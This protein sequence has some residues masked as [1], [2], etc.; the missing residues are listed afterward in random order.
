MPE[1]E[2]HGLVNG[3]ARALLSSAV[4]FALDG[5]VRDRIIA[6]TRGNPLALLELPRGL[7]PTQLAGG[8][9]MPDARDLPRRIEESY[10]RRL[11]TLPD[12]ARRLLLVA[13]AEPVGDPLLLQRACERLG[14]ARSAAV[15]ATDGLL[16]LEERVTFRHPLAR[17]AVYRS[18]DA[19]G[20]PGG[21]PGAGGGD[22]SGR[23][24]RIGARGIW[25]R[26]PPGPTR[27]SRASWSCSAGRAQ[28]RGG[29][30]AAAAFLQRAVALTGDPRAAGRPSARGRPGQPRRGRVRRG[31]RA[32]GG[33]GG[34]AARRARAGPRGPAPGRG[35]VRPEP[36]R[37]RPAAAARRPRGSSRR[38]TCGS[39]RDTYLDAWSAALFA[40]RLAARRQPARRLPR[41]GDRARSG[42]SSAAARPAAGRPRADLHRGARR[43]D[44]RAP[45]RGRRVR[46]R[47]GLRRRRC[48]A[49]AGWRRGRRTSCGTTT[50]ALEIG[51]R[52]VQLAR[53]SGALEVLA[54]AD[55]AYGQ[56]AAFGG[57]FATA[58]LLI[59][60]VDAV[61]EA[62]GTR[63]APHA[64]IALAGIRGREAE[65]S[66]L[67]DGVI[68]EA[69][70]ARPGDRRPV[71]ALGER[72]C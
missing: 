6:E 24:T 16:A 66:E 70:A 42:R 31:P 28:A 14:I 12:D 10:V 55:N 15:D 25:P 8:F 62:T 39:S 35:R 4:R 30:A 58:A 67:I 13:A 38:S 1:L 71:R 53:D 68:A 20:A 72:P 26:R 32:A 48:C 37:R 47:R 23:P 34:R 29:L 3:D 69:T 60:E 51:T 2:V 19:A 50:A 33:R 52:A 57:D 5:R 22:G 7:T 56:A 41:R 46:G 17:S 9:G 54:V 18:A 49:G 44:A 45:A 64:A 21:T 27:R 63:I 36:R 65:A 61:K 59:A 40:G 11:E 43:R